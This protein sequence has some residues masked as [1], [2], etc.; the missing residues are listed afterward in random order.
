[1][2]TLEEGWALLKSPATLLSIWQLV[3]GDLRFQKKVEYIFV[4]Q[5]AAKLQPVKF[6]SSR[7]IYAQVWLLRKATILVSKVRFAV[8]KKFAGIFYDVFVLGGQIGG[9]MAILGSIFKLGKSFGNLRLK[10]GQKWPHLRNFCL[11]K[12]KFG[13][14]TTFCE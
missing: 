10:K 1:M 2:S 5:R 11:P 7:Y 3:K 14:W 12:T 6:E 13:V 9:K 8:C 4:A